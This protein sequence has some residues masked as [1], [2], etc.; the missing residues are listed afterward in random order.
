MTRTLATLATAALC[1]TFTA[2]ASDDAPVE[3]DPVDVS[4]D[5]DVPVDP[6]VGDGIDTEVEQSENLGF[7]E[8]DEG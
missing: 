8:P 7:E 6:D 1:L 2:C 5:E 4:T 3:D